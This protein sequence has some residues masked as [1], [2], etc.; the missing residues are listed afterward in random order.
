MNTEKYSNQNPNVSPSPIDLAPTSDFKK[1]DFDAIDKFF[2]ENKSDFMTKH[3][4]EE[5]FMNK[6]SCHWPEI[7]DTKDIRGRGD[8]AL[9]ADALEAWGHCMDGNKPHPNIGEVLVMIG[10]RLGITATAENCEAWAKE[11]LNEQKRNS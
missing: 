4:T 6:R 8:A 11:W 10:D 9:C 2:E 3:E 7:F 1:K 5:E